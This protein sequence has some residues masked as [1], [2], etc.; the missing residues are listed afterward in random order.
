[1]LLLAIGMT[2]AC[3]TRADDPQMPR[4]LSEAIAM[5]R[6]DALPRT[7]FYDSPSLA[8]TKPGDLL[9]KAPFSGYTVPQGA[10]TVRILYHSLNAAGNA[11][12]TSGVVLIPAGKPP[13]GG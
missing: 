11:V 10:S 1:M 2:A 3:A 8:T 4:S 6:A 7:S 12:A 9:R 5:E 13:A